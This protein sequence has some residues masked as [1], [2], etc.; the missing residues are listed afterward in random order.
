MA[1][2]FADDLIQVGSGDAVVLFQP[3]PLLLDIDDLVERGPP[4]HQR[5]ISEFLSFGPRKLRAGVAV[6][7]ASRLARRIAVF[8]RLPGYLRAA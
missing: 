3:T 6:T 2:G 5:C 8:V 7:F 4:I 1:S